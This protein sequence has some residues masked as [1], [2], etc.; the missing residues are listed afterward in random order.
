MN[1]Q[2]GAGQVVGTSKSA[3]SPIEVSHPGTPFEAGVGSG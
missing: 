3:V 2:M 1:Y